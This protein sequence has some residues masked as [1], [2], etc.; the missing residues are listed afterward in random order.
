M[1]II[2]ADDDPEDIESVREAF[3]EIDRN[4][5]CHS[6][7]DGHEL[8]S[9]LESTVVAPDLIILDINMPGVDGVSC[10]KRL[11]MAQD[12]A[13]IPVVMFTTGTRPEDINSA[14]KLGALE[15]ISKP[16]SYDELV[17]IFRPLIAKV[18]AA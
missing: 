7:A 11:K 12:Y 17:K 9:F 4:L 6:V 18:K 16:N 1:L 3:A 15:Y 8:F 14:K 5:I 10:L 2:Y 13:D